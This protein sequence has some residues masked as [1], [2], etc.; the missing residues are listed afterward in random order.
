MRRH[1]PRTLAAFASHETMRLLMERLDVEPDGLT[2]F[3]ILSAL[4]ALRRARP[5]VELDRDHILS[6]A[7]ATLGRAAELL[8]GRRGSDI[9]RA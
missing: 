9:E 4:V 5:D 3:K 7:R 6:L 8:K 2:R 1:L